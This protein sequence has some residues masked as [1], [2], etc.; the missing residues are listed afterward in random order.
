M[1]D[2]K[3]SKH[4][5]RDDREHSSKKRH[6]HRDEEERKHKKKRK[7]EK[8]LNIVEDDA[9][10]DMWVEKNIDMDGEKVREIAIFFFY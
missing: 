10:D 4:K 2:D 8:H 9:D 1:G 5:H 6:R 7:E 3:K